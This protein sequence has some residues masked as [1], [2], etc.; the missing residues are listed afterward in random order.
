MLP[1]GIQSVIFFYCDIFHRGLQTYNSRMVCSSVREL[2]VSWFLY[3]MAA[4]NTLRTYDV[5]TGIFREKKIEFDPSFDVT[6]CLHQIEI[7]DLL[8]VRRVK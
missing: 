7:P 1:L 8:Y 6:K 5:K 2:S 4:Q 3:K